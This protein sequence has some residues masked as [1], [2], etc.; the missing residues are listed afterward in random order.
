M[1]TRIDVCWSAAKGL[2][3]LDPIR[4][5]NFQA[6]HMLLALRAGEPYRVSRALSFEAGH[7]AQRGLMARARTAQLLQSATAI[8]E[9]IDHPYA[10]GLALSVATVSAFLEGRWRESLEQSERAEP[11]LR[12]RCRG[13]AWEL[14]NTHYYSLAALFY[15]GE[16]KRLR[17]ALP[18]FVKEAGDRGDRYALTSMRTRL[19][20]LVLLAN[21]EP[22]KAREELRDAITSWHVEGFLLQHWYAMMGEAEC[23]LYVGAGSAALRL[24]GKRWPALRRSMI[25]RAQSVLIHSLYGRARAAVAASSTGSGG[26]AGVLD[27]AEE[28]ASRIE[29]EQ[30]PWGDGLAGLVRAGIASARRERDRALGLAAGAERDLSAADM[31]LHAAVARRRRGELLGGAQGAALVEAA[32]AWM[33]ERLVRN[34]ERITRMLAPGPASEAG[35]ALR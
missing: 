9:R 26:N 6:Q 17:E 16:I 1:L 28:D 2:T 27:A 8:A 30:T 5:Q 20:P 14:D 10:I 18:E 35:Q 25:L 4:G 7:S 31:A 13:V 29:R 34:P 19:A 21:D 22:E 12:D 11:V 15:L 33:S 23:L 24:I 32:D 3:L